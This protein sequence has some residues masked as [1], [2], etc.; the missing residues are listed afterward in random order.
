MQRVTELKNF[1]TYYCGFFESNNSVKIFPKL[2]FLIIDDEEVIFASSNYNN[3]LCSLYNREVVGIL[4]IY[5]NECWSLCSII[6]DYDGIH[7]DNLNAAMED[8]K[9]K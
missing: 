4:T 8:F 1:D 2:H 6:K 3:Y 5:F 7:Q 9:K